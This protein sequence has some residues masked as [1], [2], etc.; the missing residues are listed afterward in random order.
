[1]DIKAEQKYILTS[2]RKLREIVGAVKGTKP[3][4]AYEKLFFVK[5]R[6]VQPLR[7]VIGCAIANAKQAG[8]NEGD[9]IFKEIQINQGPGLKRWRAGARGRAKPY[10]KRMCHIR[11]LLTTKEQGDEIKREEK[12]SEEKKGEK[13]GKI[14]ENLLKKSRE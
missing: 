8:L 1:M 12:T 3:V 13:H 10:K 4:E 9:L 7:K 2:P 14:S 11:V 5:K 6:A